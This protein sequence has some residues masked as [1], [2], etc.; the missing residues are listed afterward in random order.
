MI[1]NIILDVGMVL[2]DFCWQDV[3]QKLHIEGRDFETVAAAT[4][5][6][7]LWN[8]YDRSVVSDEEI[9]AR[10]QEKAPDH[11][12]Q[13]QLFW[14]HTADT[15]VQYPYAKT[16]IQ[17]MKDDGFQVYILSNY[18]RRTYE[19]TKGEGLNF[20]PLVDGA[21]F[22][23]EAGYIKP[24]KEIYHFLMDQYDLKPRECVFI[25][26]NA[27]NLTYPREIGWSTI[28]FHTFSQVQ[29][30]LKTILHTKNTDLT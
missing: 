1:K 5:R 6:S 14:E 13:V 8:E 25:D 3:M 18:S 2:V 17:S 21:V 28:Q 27:I 24:E 22:S 26:D 30:E 19:L 15:I 11:K 16:W 23:F 9:L 10:F 7:P 29:E 12:Q 4:V 20:L